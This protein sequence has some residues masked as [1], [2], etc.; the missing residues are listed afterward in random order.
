MLV[1]T[2]SVQI[3]NDRT[4]RLGAAEPVLTTCSQFLYYSHMKVTEIK[5]MAKNLNVPIGKKR[6]KELIHAIQEAEG[7][8]ACFDSGI[9]DCGLTDCLWYSDCQK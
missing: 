2:I 6:K 4:S 9:T 1:F 3:G 5:V 8:T 7:H